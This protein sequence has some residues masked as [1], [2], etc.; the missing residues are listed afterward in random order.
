MCRGDAPARRG[1][2]RSDRLRCA[3]DEQ[4]ALA[5]KWAEPPRDALDTMILKTGLKLP[6]V[7]L[8]ALARNGLAFASPATESF[9]TL[10]LKSL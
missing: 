6:Q 1:L 9:S 8:S 4:A 2:G 3:P 7:P 5:A 10:A